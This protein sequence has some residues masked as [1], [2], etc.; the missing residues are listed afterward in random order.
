MKQARYLGTL[1]AA[2]GLTGCITI[3]PP[4]SSPPSGLRARL[5]IQ[6]DVPADSLWLETYVDGLSCAGPRKF[7]LPDR[8][9]INL[10]VPIHADRPLTLNVF[11]R[12]TARYGMCTAT[13]TFLPKENGSY[14]VKLRYEPRFCGAALSDLSSTGELTLNGGVLP[15]DWRYGAD[16][17]QW[18]KPVSAE[19]LE[20]VLDS[21]LGA[22][23]TKIE[24]LK[25]LIA[26]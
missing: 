22:K 19:D 10:D 12:P 9:D 4:Y 25:E 18:C 24:D 15:R 17:G 23:R 3:L 11:F 26:K 16:N 20:A 2:L 5:Q 14:L 7:K 21:R 1:I 13:G 8:P 6:G